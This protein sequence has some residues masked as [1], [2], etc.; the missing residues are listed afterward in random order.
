MPKK[1]KKAGLSIA[2]DFLGFMGT[3]GLIAGFIAF[4]GEKPNAGTAILLSLLVIASAFIV[5]KLHNIDFN[6][7][8]QE[9]FLKKVLEKNKLTDKDS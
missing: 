6:T 4:F 8:Q 2:S 5:Q 7:R 1:T 9:K 3:L